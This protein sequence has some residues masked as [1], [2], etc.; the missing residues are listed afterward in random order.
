MLLYSIYQILPS[1]RDR[2]IHKIIGWPFGLINMF[3]TL[4]LIASAADGSLEQPYSTIGALFTV[5]IIIIML[6]Y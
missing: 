5:I 1:Q 4:W 6:K 3:F 2:K